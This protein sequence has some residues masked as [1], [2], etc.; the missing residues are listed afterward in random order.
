MTDTDD[1]EREAEHGEKM[2]EIKVRFLTNRI[3]NRPGHIAWARALLRGGQDRAQRSARHHA[4]EATAGAVQLVVGPGGAI[5]QVLIKNRIT[6]HASQGRPGTSSRR[7][8]VSSNW[9]GVMAG[10]APWFFCPV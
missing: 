3:A 6:L 8:D 7:G 4:Q 10:D 2:I 5:E 1:D 9:R